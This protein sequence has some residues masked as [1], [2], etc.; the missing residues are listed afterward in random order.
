[1]Q[2]SP[3]SHAGA[4]DIAGI[5]MDFRGYQHNVAFWGSITFTWQAF[6]HV[7]AFNMCNTTVKMVA[8]CEFR[9]A[10][11]I[12]K[13]PCYGLQLISFAIRPWVKT[14]EDE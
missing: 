3:G 14:T 9:V 5:P 13:Y 12:L 1:V 7:L 6:S 10:R 2:I 4:A 8:C 11:L